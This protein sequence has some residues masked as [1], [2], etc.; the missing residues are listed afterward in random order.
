MT[1]PFLPGELDL[2]RAINAAHTPYWDAA[3]WL[4]SNFAAWIYPGLVLLFFLFWRKPWREGVLVLLA[5]ALCVACGD[6]LS[7][8]IAKPFFARFRPTHTPW[9][10]ESLQYVYGYHGGLYG[11]FSGHSANYTTVATLLCLILRHRGFTAVMTL[12]VG[13][14]VYSRM[15]LGAHFLSDCLVG[16]AV[17]FTIA[18][19]VYRLYLRLRQ[20]W[21]GAGQL[22]PAQRYAPVAG[23]LSWAIAMTI[24]LT[25]TM[26]LQVSR[27]VR[28]VLSSSL[29]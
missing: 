25:L 16:I 27:I 8:W 19:V 14:V 2:L 1:V 18:Q 5:I 21:L 4:I 28:D 22:S 29:P 9:L 23:Y 24:P 7:S 11:F 3:M 10:Q 17:G 15:Y 20:Q 26:A 12:L 6:L 13:W